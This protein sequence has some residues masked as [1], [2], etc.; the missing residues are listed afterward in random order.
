MNDRGVLRAI[1]SARAIAS[2]MPFVSGVSTS[3][4]P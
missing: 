3:S 4:A 1:S 2:C